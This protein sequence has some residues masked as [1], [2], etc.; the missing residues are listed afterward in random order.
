LSQ[1]PDL[2]GSRGDS[3]RVALG[4]RVACGHCAAGWCEG[5]LRTAIGELAAGDDRRPLRFSK[6]GDPGIEK[7]YRTHWVAPE[8]S[9]RKRARLAERQSRPPDLV[10]VSPVKHWECSVC[11]SE[12]GGWLI[13]ENSGPVCMSCA[14]MG[15][16]VFLPSGDAAKPAAC[17]RWSCASAVHAGGMSVR[18]SSWRRAR[19][20]T[21]GSRPSAR[22]VVCISSRRSPTDALTSAGRAS[23]PQ[24]ASACPTA[25]RRGR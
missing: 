7:A 8:L 12:D 6:S 18:G 11:G 3:C 1:W 13:M 4:G 19:S 15:H 23:A 21:S 20:R 5:R 24:P 2:L 25:A 9:E 16:L 10:V 17:R 14:D 22:A